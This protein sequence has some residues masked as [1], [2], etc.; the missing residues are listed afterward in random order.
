ME[1]FVKKNIEFK[2]KDFDD[3]S[4]LVQFYINK[5]GSVD[6]HGD[7]FVPESINYNPRDL[8]HFKNHDWN[9]PV[10]VVKEVAQDEHGYFVTSEILPTTLGNDTLIEYQKGAINQHSIGGY[11]KDGYWNGED[12][13]IK[14]F[15]LWEVSSLTHWGAQPDTP[16]ISIKEKS[17]PKE[18]D[19]G[20]EFFN[21]Y[22]KALFGEI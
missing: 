2:L 21:H 5:F 18:K 8:K 17:K 1:N 15:D 4:R 7:I 6:S 3:N 11:I 20:K 10:G 13:V 9:L 19:L 14:S 12:Y 22:I 16:V